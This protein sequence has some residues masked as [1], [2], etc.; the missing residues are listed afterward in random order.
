MNM[1]GNSLNNWNYFKASWNN[2]AIA[3]ELNKKSNPVQV[4]TLLSV[5]GKECY[6]VYENL[7][8]TVDERK[9]NDSI[10]SKL[11]EYF[12]PQRNIIYERYLFNSATQRSENKIDQFVNELRKLASTCE[13]G[14]LSDELI[15]DRIVIGISD[16]SM[17]ARLLRESDLTLNR[18]ID[19]CRASEQATC[20]LRELDHDSEVVQYTKHN[21]SNHKNNKAQN[22]KKSR[23]I[24]VTNC[25][26]CG[27]SHKK[28]Q[29]PAFGK[30]CNK[31]KQI[32][33]FGK[34]CA[35]RSKSQEL[36][37]CEEN[38]E[39]SDSAYTINSRPHSNT[40]QYFTVLQVKPIDSVNMF[41]M[42]FQVDSGATCNTMNLHDYKQLTK[43][44]PLP[45][46]TRLKTYSNTIIKPVGQTTLKCRAGSVVKNVHFEIVKDAPTSLLS[47]KASEELD[48][49]QFNAEHLLHNVTVE[50]SEEQVV[51]EYSD[52]FKGLGKLDAKYHIDIDD[53][54]PAVQCTKRRIPM[55]VR[56]AL[57]DKL[58]D[59]VDKNIITKVTTPTQW[60]SN[61]VCVQR[62]NKLRICLDPV[63]LNKAIRRCHYPIATVEE[64]SSNLAKAKV[65]SVV[66]AKDGFLQVELDRD[67]S[68]LTTFWTPHGRFRWLR[69]P[70]GLS[71][72]PEVFQRKLDECLEGLENIQVIADD[73]LIYGTGDTTEEAVLQHDKAM[74]ALL[75]RCREQGLKLNSRKL[76]FKLDKVAYMGHVFSSEGLLPDPE[77]VSAVS[78]MPIPENVAAVHRLLG[79]VTY[80][81]KFVPKLSTIAE[82]L[83]RLTHKDSVFE[84]SE[85]Q[86][87]AVSQIKAVLCSAPVLQYYDVKKET[88]IECDSSEHGLG[89]VVTQEGKPVAYASRTLTSTERNYAQIEKEALAV[90][91]ACER[92]EQYIMGKETTVLS[93]HKPLMNIFAKP[94][95]T[96]PKR[97]QRMRL[98][99]Q[100][101]TIKVQYKPG[102]QMHISDTLSRA[103]L[104]ISSRDNSTPNYLVFQLKREED[105]RAE[106]ENV[107]MKDDLFV[108][109][110]R[111]NGIRR[112]TKTDSTLQT[113]MNVVKKGF[114]EDKNELPVCVRDYWSY[115][116]ELSTQDG[117][118]YRGTRIIIPVKMRSQL[119]TRAHASHLGIQYTVNTAKEIM[120]WPRMH[121]ELVKTVKRC[122][123]C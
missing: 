11:T 47:G 79:V 15:R 68:E 30:K 46:K 59:L 48:L 90:V 61:I 97:L 38:S 1:L 27:R 121:S 92:F 72:S 29:C 18:A 53:S 78:D 112:H 98:R 60:V 108:T 34:M 70:F 4:S 36:N 102:S 101:Y 91:F 65:F 63:N 76:K 45:S 17:R 51:N 115:R 26:Y 24:N 54:V 100:K 82:P 69:M 32:G 55:S 50:L 31:C 9:D 20:Q 85:E 106:L 88:T 103:T 57:K 44:E 75:N 116:G 7:P 6:E 86:D 120:F 94:I 83:R 111:L 122:Q 8:L 2:Y 33:H 35:I 43:I 107:C 28:G 5:I 119:L 99:L 123:T 13:Y 16:S 114:P 73:I 64:I 110:E 58:D 62:N 19:M 49:I 84:W 39:N 71:S 95:L 12:E 67:S 42:K 117:L 10:I 89:A 40:K 87:R 104:P 80:M 66:D 105:T 52:V 109:D 96:S 93:D 118:V 25:Q 81:A 41:P 56:S 21:K 113:L 3:T 37:M 14:T 77:K 22:D 23:G 74:L